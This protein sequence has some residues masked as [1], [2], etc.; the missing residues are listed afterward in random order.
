MEPFAAQ[1]VLWAAQK[2]GWIAASSVS[3]Q[4]AGMKSAFLFSSSMRGSHEMDQN[5]TESSLCF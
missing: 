4:S 1:V 2:T 3:A 5:K